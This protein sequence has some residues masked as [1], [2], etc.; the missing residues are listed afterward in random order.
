MAQLARLLKHWNA[1]T[2]RAS[3][4]GPS[5]GQLLERFRSSREDAAFAA[6]LKRH[7]SMVFGVCRRILGDSDAE[8]AFQ[9]TF[10]VL[11]QSAPA[12]RKLQSV[13]SWLHGVARRLSWKAR[14]Q[15]AARKR[16][17][18]AVSARHCFEARPNAGRELQELLD[19][20]LARLPDKYRLP[21]VHCYLED[22]THDEAAAALGWPVGTVKS[23]LAKGREL[24]RAAL[25]RRGLA[26]STA[27]LATWLVSLPVAEAS[28]SLLQATTQSALL[29]L[30]GKAALASQNAV[31]LAELSKSSGGLALKPSVF[32]ISGA[33]LALGFAGF[34]WLRA[35][36]IGQ[37]S[38]P[39]RA[40]Q[41][42][43]SQTVQDKKPG[44]A[45]K[46]DRKKEKPA[47]Q[48]LGVVWLPGARFKNEIQIRDMDFAP[49][50]KTLVAHDQ[51]YILQFNVGDS[52]IDAKQE[53][54]TIVQAYFLG[55]YPF[56]DDG[57]VGGYRGLAFRRF[58]PPNAPGA[59]ASRDW[60]DPVSGQRVNLPDLVTLDYE[61]IFALSP[62]GKLLAV[63]KK[64]R[65]RLFSLAS[66]KETAALPRVRLPIW[67]LAFS[68]DGKTLAV[69]TGSQPGVNLEQ[70]AGVVELWPI[71]DKIAKS[72]VR[73]LPGNWTVRR[74]AFAPSGKYLAASQRNR[75]EVL[76]WDLK[77]VEKP[78]QF[79]YT[80]GH[81]DQVMGVAFSPDSK[82]LAANLRLQS[83]EGGAVL[84]EV[85]S[86]QPLPALKAAGLGTTIP[87]A[88]S[89]DGSLLAVVGNGIQIWEGTHLLR[90]DA[91]FDP[92]PERA[93]AQLTGAN[94]KPKHILNEPIKKLADGIKLV[95]EA[96][97]QRLYAAAE[98]DGWFFYASVA[99]RGQ[100]LP[101]FMISGY[102]VKKGGNEVFAWSVW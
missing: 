25:C 81:N 66:G 77:D 52:P 78:M 70:E 74:L 37:V 27:G 54:K 62:D 72:D 20:E 3:G 29:V 67:S 73:L 82:L 9:A 14:S 18:H 91:K 71:S 36:A 96:S 32:F 24:L 76:V 68:A 43:P 60:F 2:D 101:A 41:D 53:P 89:P 88:F 46:D 1:L 64:D 15:A 6:L 48:R 95:R 22:E 17:E 87:V 33:I 93:M 50:G 8:D 100:D 21:L 12:I 69:G 79:R 84:W 92:V 23:R 65:L 40:Q 42:R 102:A 34:L 55:Y 85:P 31:A 45:N 28:P 97:G 58:V 26:L 35:Q 5:D 90:A 38:D 4:A 39:T 44:E 30:A 59:E 61:E 57:R 16:R 63:A 56:E 75:Q 94:A 47:A 99:A 11:A 51:G 86:G 83:G 98:Y 80:E 13:G 49:D 7:G 19:N 10:L